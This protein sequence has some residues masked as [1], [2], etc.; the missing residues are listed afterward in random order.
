MKEVFKKMFG[1]APMSA[2]ER[3]AFA[4]LPVV[5]VFG[6]VLFGVAVVFG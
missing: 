1:R 4:L 6:F 2:E 3:E 5:V